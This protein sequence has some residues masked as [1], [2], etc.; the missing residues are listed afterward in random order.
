MLDRQKIDWIF[1][2]IGKPV[3]TGLFVAALLMLMFPQFRGDSTDFNNLAQKD[4]T[5]S[6]DW[7]GPVSYAAAVRRAAP[8]VVNIYTRKLRREKTH[9]LLNDPFIRRFFNYQQQRLQSSL[10]SGIIVRDDGFIMTNNHVVANVDE[11]VVLLY[12]GRDV[13]AKIVGTDPDTDLAILKIDVDQ[14]QPISIGD[15]M[16]AKIGDVVLAI[17]NPY[18]LGQAVTQGI[19]SATGRNGLGLNTFENFIQ[20]DADINPGNSGGALVDVYGNLLGINTAKLD[21]SGA[22][23]MS[24]AIPV[25]E[26]QKVLNDIIQYG[27]V[28]RGWLGMDATPLNQDLARHFNTSTTRGLLVNGVFNTGPAQKAGIRPGD[29]VIGINGT[30]VTDRHSSASQIADVMPGQPIKLEILRGIETFT[31]TAIAGTRPV[32]AQ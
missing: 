1:N 13:P 21:R 9:P 3:L 17:G 11:I 24:F 10:G 4:D 16:D 29:I 2:Y 28:I 22:A 19:I 31:L 20:T 18:G 12:D 8:S 32:I 23:G 25:N 30:A 15:A 7:L 27:R 6:S 5:A 14:L 26:A